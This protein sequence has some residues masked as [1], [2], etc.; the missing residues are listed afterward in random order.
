MPRCLTA[1][2]VRRERERG[3]LTLLAI[4]IALSALAS[5]GFAAPASAAPAN[6]S[7]L[8]PAEQGI[9]A[10]QRAFA[11]GSQGVWNGHRNVPLA[12]YDE[13]LHVHIRYPLATIWGAV[14]LFEA[15]CSV[16]IADPSQADR[17]P[18]DGPAAASRGC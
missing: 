1:I 15:L 16:A 10:A 12:W 18:F 13:R 11:D 4:M 6:Q 2:F 7:F 8:S 9:S 14:P 17:P 3:A 5:G